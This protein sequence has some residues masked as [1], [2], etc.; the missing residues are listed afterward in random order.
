MKSDTSSNNAFLYLQAQSASAQSPVTSALGANNGVRL[1]LQGGQGIF[2]VETG[3]SESLR[4]SANGDVTTTGASY[5]RANAGFTARKG[6]SVNITRASGTPLEINRTGNNGT[7]INFFKDQNIIGSVGVDG[8]DVWFGANGSA[9]DES[10][11]IAS[12]GNVGIN[13]T[14]PYYKLHLNFTNNTT[15]L[16]GGTGGNWGGNGIRIENDSTTAGAMALIHFRVYSADWHIGNRY[17]STSPDKSDFVFLHEGT[18]EKLRIDPDGRAL[19]GAVRTYDTG[20]YY[21]D[22]TINNSNTTSGSAGG[23]GI[24]LVSGNASWGGLIF[25]DND[26]H[27]RGFVK[28]SHN[29]DELVFGTASNNRVIFTSGGLVKI[30]SASPASGSNGVNALLQVKSTSQ[31]D[32]L[33]LGTAYTYGTIGT[34]NKGA[35][36]Y[37]GNAGPGNL[38][39]GEKITHEWWSGTAGGGGPHQI[40]ALSASGKLGINIA[41]SD[42]TSPVRNL[43]IADSSGAILRL[44]STDD[45]L[46]ASQRLGEIEFYSDDDDKAHIGAFIKAIADPSDA[47][48]RRTAL[49]FGTQNHDTNINAVEKVRI[50]CNGNVTIDGGTSTLVKIRADSGGTAGLRLGGQAGSGSDQCTGFV[51]VHQDESHGGGMFYNGDG[52]PS[53]AS[54]G[55]AAD[56]FSLYRFSSG[57]RHVVQRWFH[58]SNNCQMLGDL[59][60]DNGASSLLRIKCQ[61][62]GN[63]IVMAGGTGQGT[64]AFE[65]T[66]D[67][68]DHGGGIFYNGDGTPGFA[69]NESA[70]RITFY[71][72]HN[73]TRYE[74][75]SSSYNSNDVRYRGHIHPAQ[76]NIKDVG[77]SSTRW[78]DVYA[79]NT[80]IQTSDE[81][82]KQDIA[83]LT[84]AEMNAAKRMSALFKTFRWKDRVSEKGDKARTHTGIIA[85]QVKAALEAESLDSSKYAFLV[86]SEWYQNA[87]GEV[88][89]LEDKDDNDLTGY[90]KVDRYS[91]R[92]GELL[93]FIAAYNEQRFASIESRLSALEGS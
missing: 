17:V 46:G 55:E 19:L 62:A 14:D 75:F 16:S 25:S 9:Y 51:E 20:T 10:V 12:D 36:I 69:T 11:R 50:D 26:M 74:V 65:C 91:I 93:A 71:R 72:V 42:N 53:F 38:G 77:T 41:A 37:T 22:I 68:G 59:E 30:N 35:L 34:N 54:S 3:A 84:T 67:N 27:G 58:N 5:T 57:S 39:G 8:S 33:L 31:Y 28:Y 66:Q 81:R 64:G 79:T 21:D 15:S 1:I 89:N 2:A 63:A 92:I 43:D 44:I 24:S 78:D 52:S 61:N 23:A 60:I 82:L 48:G 13:Q 7:V 18:E 83:S 49:L 45:S 80:T 70:D 6:D 29:D 86:Y 4:I 87:K 85:Q 56:Y 73:G 88:I 47:A 76:D 90:T 40:M 32:G